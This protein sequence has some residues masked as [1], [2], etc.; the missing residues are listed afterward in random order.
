VRQCAAIRWWITEKFFQFASGI[1]RQPLI[2][3]L[4]SGLE[5]VRIDGMFAAEA[6]QLSGGTWPARFSHPLKLK[7]RSA[8]PAREV[9][10]KKRETLRAFAPKM[11]LM[12]AGRTEIDQSVATS[13]KLL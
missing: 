9:E 6:D 7:S 1:S 8:L 4:Q 5:Y 2:T 12:W 13:Q 11:P 3:F 10:L